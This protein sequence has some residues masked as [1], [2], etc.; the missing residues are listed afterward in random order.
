[1]FSCLAEILVNLDSYC[2]IFYDGVLLLGS[3]GIRQCCDVCSLANFRS[4]MLVSKRNKE[5]AIKTF[6]ETFRGT[7]HS[8]NPLLLKGKD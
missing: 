2:I 6:F 1:M 5:I 3:N 8:V 7:F 4:W